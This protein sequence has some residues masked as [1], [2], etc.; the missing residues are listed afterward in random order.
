GSPGSPQKLGDKSSASSVSEGK[1]RVS[2]PEKAPREEVSTVASAFWTSR[3]KTVPSEGRIL[4]LPGFSSARPTQ[5]ESVAQARTVIAAWSGSRA[6][7]RSA[8]RRIG[9]IIA[10]AARRFQ[11]IVLSVSR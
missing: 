3:L 4:A 10:H 11:V 1:T 6:F 9:G 5:G 2:C 7:R 8:D